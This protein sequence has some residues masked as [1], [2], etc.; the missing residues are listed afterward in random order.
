MRN[1]VFFGAGLLLIALTGCEPSGISA[2]AVISSQDASA[3][4]PNPAVTPTMT[5]TPTPT[6]TAGSLTR[7]TVIGEQSFILPSNAA[8]GDMV[9]EVTTY[10]RLFN[11]AAPSLSVSANTANNNFQISPA[12]AIFVNSLAGLAAGQTYSIT[13]RA[14]DASKMIDDEKPMTITLINS[15]NIRFIDPTYTGSGDGSRAMPFATWAQ[16]NA[17]MNAG[18]VLLQK[19]G[20]SA[21]L[22]SFAFSKSGTNDVTLG[23]YGAGPRPIMNFSVSQSNSK[24]IDT[25]G[26]TGITIRD[27]DLRAPFATTAIL[28]GTGSNNSAVRNCVVSGAEYGMRVYSALD[29]KVMNSEIHHV[30]DDGL[31]A[32]T[33]G[34]V[35]VSIEA[36]FN[37]F[38]HV[39]QNYTA[40][41]TPQTIASGDGLQFNGRVDSL[42]IHHNIID[43][44]DTGNKFCLILS[45]ADHTTH[46]NI[47]HNYCKANDSVSSTTGN[48]VTG[49][50]FE[51]TNI[52]GGNDNDIILT[53]NKFENVNY[54]VFSRDF[55]SMKFYSNQFSDLNIAIQLGDYTGGEV[56]NNLF[57]NIR[58]RVITFASVT[59]GLPVRLQ[60][61]IYAVAPNVQIYG[62]HVSKIS[63]S[64]YNVF[65]HQSNGFVNGFAS[66]ATWRASGKDTL[67]IVGTPN[68]VNAAAGDFRLVP[69]SIGTGD[70]VSAGLLTDILGNGYQNPVHI[71]PYQTLGN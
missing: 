16:A 7:R 21:D 12:G 59:G 68:F 11:A 67:S 19:R 49:F 63:E 26:R 37:Y 51:N 62:S 69:T 38:H 54:G 6:M 48:P 47:S 55:R 44:S 30:K 34:T 32:T 39:N 41:G 5:V 42:N 57:H 25:Y 60:N 71:G 61:N 9:G 18:M 20:T 50:Y 27:L 14:F 66:M 22:A 36:G 35:N 24:A 10:Y 4:K 64:N 3:I 56:I 2:K 45:P 29:L 28:I 70:G 23:A 46:A 40:P 58:T 13:I 31:Y 43:R 17:A 53:G 8:V 52:A 33:P 15:S 65:S 1:M